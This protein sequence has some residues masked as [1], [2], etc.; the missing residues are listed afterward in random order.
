MKPTHV[1]VTSDWHGDWL[2]DGQWR[3][4]DLEQQTDALLDAIERD[5][6]AMQI[7]VFLGDL[8][9]PYSRHVHHAVA[10]GVRVA[11]RLNQLGVP[12]YWLVGNHDIIEDDKVSHTLLELKA[13]EDQLTLVIDRPTHSRFGANAEAIWLPYTSPRNN[14]SPAE[15]VSNVKGLGLKRLI[16]GHL[17][18]E[19]IT[20]GSETTSMAR[21]RDVFWPF[22]AIANAG[23][24]DALWFNG[25]YHEA[26]TFRG[27]HIPGAL[28]RLCHGEEQNNPGYLRFAL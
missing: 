26:Q 17:N 16:F 3:L 24:G 10:H 25:H 20:A 15:F 23:W 19:G 9:N 21:G 2:T 18:I 4:K 1:Y 14:Y 7:F 5:E 13:I 22:D 12:N 28:L 8:S 11:C 6:G 27:I